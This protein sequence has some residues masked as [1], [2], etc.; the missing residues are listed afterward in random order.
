MSFVATAGNEETYRCHRL[1]P[2][3]ADSKERHWERNKSEELH[4]TDDTVYSN[5]MVSILLKIEM[6]LI[7][8]FYTIQNEEQLRSAL[9]HDEGKEG[10]TSSA[11]DPEA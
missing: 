1:G 10:S 8:R 9:P 11:N 7:Q 4:D 6:I 3:S 2:V 5:Y